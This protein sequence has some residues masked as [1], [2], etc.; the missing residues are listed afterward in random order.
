MLKNHFVSSQLENEAITRIIH[1][2]L[3][4]E[5]I[6]NNIKKV[7]SKRA[8]TFDIVKSNIPFYSQ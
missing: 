1:L 3:R 5:I 8:K 2:G 6:E 4:L 7:K